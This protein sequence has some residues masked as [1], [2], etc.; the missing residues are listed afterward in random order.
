VEVAALNTSVM[1]QVLG[2]NTINKFWSKFIQYFG[3]L[4]PFTK[5]FLIQK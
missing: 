1:A 5:M 4:D 2:F 3:N